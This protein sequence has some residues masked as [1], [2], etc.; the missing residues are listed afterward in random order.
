MLG[1][2]LLR[3]VSLTIDQPTLF[4]AFAAQVAKEEALARVENNADPQWKTDMLA[5]IMNVASQSSLFTTDDVWKELDAS[6][7]SCTHE[8]RALGAIMQI[9]ARNGAI[10][11]TDNYRPSCRVVCHARP[12]RIWQSRLSNP[13][14]R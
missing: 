5:A 13:Q 6:S 10:V 4:D 3:V 14:L 7:S 1:F 2:L 11:A 8:P 12:V 9:A